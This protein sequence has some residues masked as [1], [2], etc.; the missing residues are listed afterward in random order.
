MTAWIRFLYN[1]YMRLVTSDNLS[2][3]S[4]LKKLHCMAKEKSN[5]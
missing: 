1:I 2:C 3:F 4:G 5:F